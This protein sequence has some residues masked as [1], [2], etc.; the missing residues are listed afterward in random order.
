MATMNYS[1]KVEGDPSLL[2]DANMGFHGDG[3]GMGMNMGVGAPG[4]VGFSAS[5]DGSAN[6]NMNLGMPNVNMHVADVRGFF[7]VI[8]KAL[9][10][11][12][13]RCADPLGVTPP[14]WPLAT[15]AFFRFVKNRA[16]LMFTSV[17]SPC[18]PMLLLRCAGLVLLLLAL[19]LFFF[20]LPI[21]F[22]MVPAGSQWA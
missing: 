7:S 19:V 9:N 14:I 11:R 18:R 20:P 4:G 21:V 10:F 6:I 15:D 2:A 8:F 12:V 1:V 17:E 5:G 13:A 16:M 3:F 22:A